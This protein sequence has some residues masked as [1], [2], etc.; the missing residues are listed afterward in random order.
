MKFGTSGLRGL[1]ADLKGRSSALYAAAFG[2]YL[3]Q[4]KKAEQGDA[5]LIGRDY[6]D[7]SPEI[8]GNC[9]GAT[10]NFST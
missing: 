1:S 2:K 6:R 4:S 8:A 7:S 10:V 3:L 5:I 9:A